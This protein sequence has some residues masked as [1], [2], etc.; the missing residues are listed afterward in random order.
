MTLTIG[1]LA[2]AAG[3]K[4][5]T[6]RY[7]ERIGLLPT[8]PRTAGNYRAY[9]EAERGRLA[10]IRRA[11]ELG[12]PIDQVRTLLDLADQRDQSCATVDTLAHA[13]LAV[14]ERKIADLQA[15]GRELSG[16]IDQCGRGAIADC[17][18]IAALAPDT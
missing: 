12:F 5:E 15:L 18:I 3:V 13:H 16:M 2:R 14:V 17:R 8:P 6:V 10:F 11:R 9:G 1:D 7:Y 4:V